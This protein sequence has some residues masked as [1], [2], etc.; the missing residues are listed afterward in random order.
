[1]TIV[2]QG[3]TVCLNATVLIGGREDLRSV[4]DSWHCMLLTSSWAYA[5]CTS[6]S[7]PTYSR[8]GTK[9]MSYSICKWQIVG[10]VLIR[11]QQQVVRY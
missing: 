11:R 1:M 8:A 6:S 9:Q 2:T 4:R 7:L 3:F 10:A 5:R